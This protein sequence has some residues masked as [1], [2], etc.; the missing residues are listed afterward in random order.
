MAHGRTSQAGLDN[1]LLAVLALLLCCGIPALPIYL[2]RKGRLSARWGLG[3]AAA[4]VAFVLVAVAVTPSEE[5]GPERA[6]DRSRENAPAALADLP[7][8]SPAT[9]PAAPTSSPAA[10]PKPKPKPQ[11]K[12]KPKPK[13]KPEPKPAPEP[14]TDPLFGTCAE[15]NDHGFGNY[16]RGTDPEYSHYQDRDGDGVVCEF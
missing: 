6:D 7:S 16:H 5:S 2:W 8:S 3:L 12:P 10:Q 15:A 11:P 13:P 4:W 14:A 9:T 1:R